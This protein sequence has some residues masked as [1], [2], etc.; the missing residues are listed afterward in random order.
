MKKIFSPILA[1]F[2][3]MAC[4]ETPPETVTV[5]DKFSLQIPGYLSEAN[6]L[7]SD[8]S[9]QYQNLIKEFYVIVID[10][11]I[12]TFNEAINENQLQDI[13]S[14]DF[15]GYFSLL[16]DSFS[17]GIEIFTV[18]DQVDLT[19]NDMPAKSIEI[20]GQVDD[21]SIYYNYTVVK[22][23]TDYYQ[24]LSWTLRDKKINYL[25]QMNEIA[26]SFVEL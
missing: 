25:D 4:S 20:E 5:D 2:F 15:D 23:E 8:A 19:I 22:G 17:E 14:T 12:E 6:G 7:N 21:V 16:I 10:E 18:S 3:L 1:I 9:L 13:Y 26:K 24:I 11:D